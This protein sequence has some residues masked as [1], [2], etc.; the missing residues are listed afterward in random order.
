M[1]LIYLQSLQIHKV[2]KRKEKQEERKKLLITQLYF[3][4]EV[5]DAF[6]SGIISKEKQKSTYFS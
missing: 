3:L 1:I 6:E 5:F 4:E 2:K